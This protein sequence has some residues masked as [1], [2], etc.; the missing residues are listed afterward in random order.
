MKH[1][2]HPDK[3]PMAD[4]FLQGLR[5]RV[6]RNPA[7]QVVLPTGIVD[8]GELVRVLQAVDRARDREDRGC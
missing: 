7:G 2:P 4:A 6:E 8:V 3:S 5:E 1:T